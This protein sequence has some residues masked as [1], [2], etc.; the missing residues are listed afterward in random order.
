[1]WTKAVVYWRKTDKETIEISKD[2]PQPLETNW[3]NID[4][5]L[6]LCFWYST[7]LPELQQSKLEN[8]NPKA[9]FK[10]ILKLRGS[11]A[12]CSCCF[13][14]FRFTPHCNDYS[15]ISLG[16]FDAIE[17]FFRNG[18]ISRYYLYATPPTH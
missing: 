7:Q 11:K 17:F 8:A 13:P 9:K 5:L 16:W 4:A 1:M 2:L 15:S 14:T 3:H 10:E 12:S 18:E 6:W